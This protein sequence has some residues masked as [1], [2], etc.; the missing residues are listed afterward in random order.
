[1]KKLKLYLDTSIINFAFADDAPKQKEVTLKLFDELNRYKGYISEIVLGEIN[2]ASDI[3]KRRLFN[4]ISKYDLEELM[5]NES[6]KIL[7]DKYIEAGVIPRK[8]QEDAFHIAIASVNDL[9]AIIS[10]NFKHIVKLKTRREVVGINLYMGY[11][12]IDIYS[13]WEVIEID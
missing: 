4:F 8:Y 5:F 6:A 11:K 9:D 13:P 3:K 1:M 2:R 7:A 12:E 10:W